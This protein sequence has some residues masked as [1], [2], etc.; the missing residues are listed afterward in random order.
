M[1]VSFSRFRRINYPPGVATLALLAS[2]LA[3]QALRRRNIFAGLIVE[4]HA[5]NTVL[6]ARRFRLSGSSDLI[7]VPRSRIILIIGDR[8]DA[9][10]R[11]SRS[12]L[13]IESSGGLRSLERAF[14]VVMRRASIKLT[15]YYG[16]KNP[17]SL[18]LSLSLS[19]SFSLAAITWPS[20]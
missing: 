12:E 14:Q 15:T 19:S 7:I 4:I 3:A 16:G 5:R 11:L 10:D 18:S 8:L 17:P 6:R 20:L 1:C 2:S 13:R 9:K